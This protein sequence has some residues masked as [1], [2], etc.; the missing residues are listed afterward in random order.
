MAKNKVIIDDGFNPEFV[1][2]SFFDGALE[3][4]QLEKPEKIVIPENV[5][6]FTKRSQS[7][8]RTEFLLFYEHDVSFGNILRNPDSYLPVILGFPG[9]I[10]LDCSL[11]AHG[12]NCQYLPESG[13]WIL[14]SEAWRICN[15]KH[16]LGRRA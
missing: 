11:Y 1:E 16:T 10:T 7:I 15:P 5:I 3:I 13:D 14:L 12:A 2:D 6:P 8:D 9:M 4:P